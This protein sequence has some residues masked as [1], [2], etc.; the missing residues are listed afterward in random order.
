[1]K[2][3][4]NRRDAEAQS[5]LDLGRTI[6]GAAIEVHQHL[7]P[8]LL[9]SAYQKALEKELDLRNVSYRSQVEIPLTYKGENLGTGYRLDLLVEDKVIVEIKTVDSLI[10]V[11]EAQLLTY[12]KLTD[13]HL[14]Y[15]INFNVAL[16]KN[17]VK[18]LVHKFPEL[19]VSAPLR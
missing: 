4:V 11:H 10:N 9:E 2:E 19:R 7:G 14:G 12:L 6:I 5:W 1:M 18:R 8:G 16:L 3:E 17:G 15:L 13:K